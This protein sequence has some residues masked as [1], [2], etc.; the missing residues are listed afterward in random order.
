[1]YELLAVDLDEINDEKASS[2][3]LRNISIGEVRPQDQDQSFSTQGQ[4][5]TQD[6]RQ[7]DQD[8]GNDQGELKNKK[9]MM[10]IVTY[11]S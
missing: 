9:R 4:P 3:T 5:P 11:D 8:D 6:E 7:E 10:K 1:L 2:T